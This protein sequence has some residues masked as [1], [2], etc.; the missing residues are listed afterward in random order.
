MY[1]LIFATAR[2]T[3]RGKRIKVATQTATYRH[4]QRSSSVRVVAL[5]AYTLWW[6][7][8]VRFY[9]QRSRVVGV[10]ASPVLFWLV[11]G[12][13]LRHLVP[14]RQRCR[15]PALSRLLLSRRA[16]HDCAVHFDLHHD[17]GDRRPQRR[18]SAFRAGGA[19]AAFGHR[20]GKSAGRNNAFH[21]PGIDL[22]GLRA[23]GR[24]PHGV[25]GSSY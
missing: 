18:L 1:F 8:V 14:L 4:N 6:R 19:G 11:I 25:L 10:I 16:H 3:R 17:V 15:R 13:G 12:S 9:R 20:A 7:E 5:P 2:R 24:R 23:A 22:P 21:H